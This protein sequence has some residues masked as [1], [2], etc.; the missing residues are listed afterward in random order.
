MFQVWHDIHTN[1]LHRR[2][3]SGIYLNTLSF[4]VNPVFREFIIPCHEI[5]EFCLDDLSGSF[6]HVGLEA[7]VYTSFECLF[8]L[9][10][11][12]APVVPSGQWRV[13]LTVIQDGDSRFH[14]APQ[15]P[16]FLILNL[17]SHVYVSQWFKRMKAK[18]RRG[19]YCHRG[20]QQRNAEALCSWEEI[21]VTM[22][23]GRS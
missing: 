6:R 9:D 18:I 23:L 1:A 11:Y 12:A 19:S 20:S 4:G 2:N 17:H 3:N 15:H 10:S 13:G 5:W 22:S 14:Y 8:P 16:C 7:S 21:S